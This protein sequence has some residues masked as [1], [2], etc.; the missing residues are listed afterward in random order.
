VSHLQHA[1]ADRREVKDWR[2]SAI[3][4]SGTHHLLDG[5]PMYSA[6]YEAVQK[7][8]EP[9]LAPVRDDSGAF[10]IDA[11]GVAA[12]SLR[13]RQTWGFYDGL[14]AVEGDDGWFHIHPTGT[15]AYGARFEW[16]GNFQE[17]LCTVREI[18]GSYFHID[19]DGQNIHNSRHRYAGDFCG[20]IAVVRYVSDG[21]CGHIGRDGLPVHDARFL[22]LDVFH[23]GAARA[24]DQRG[25]FH[26]DREGLA[27]YAD[28]FAAV[29]PF[30]NGQA[31][32]E[33]FS[34]ERVVVDRAGRTTFALD[35]F[36]RAT[37][38]PA[39]ACKILIIG[40][41]GSGKS[42]VAEELSR[43]FGW[44]HA[45]IDH[46][47]RQAGDGTAAGECAAWCAFLRAA[48]HGPS[49]IIE[50]SG[51]G[52]MVHLVHRAL[53]DSGVPTLALWIITCSKI[54][55]ERTSDRAWTTPYPNF[56]VPIES[57]VEDIERRLKQEVGERGNWYGLPVEKIDGEADLKRTVDAAIA[58]V[59]R[60]V[61]AQ[62]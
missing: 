53:V 7:F 55:L 39:L 13:F 18:G 60:W 17:R 51:S 40:N 57:V 58:A 44:P 54:C 11:T 14:A 21:L 12:Y 50:F 34:G 9:G 35:G 6:R 36:R 43:T 62:H 45:S 52:P 15:P 29:E 31:L 47:R 19:A 41:I 1:E 61:K 22:D 38:S 20:G 27:L 26:I 25:W 56:A 37:S 59:T 16:C 10:H 2:S 8:H 33:T 48:Q 30:Y 24:R 3:A 46:Y 49:S 23:K 4:P 5:V 42:T 32:C 28:R